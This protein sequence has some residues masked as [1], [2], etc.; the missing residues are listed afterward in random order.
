MY[1]NKIDD[2]FDNIINKFNIYL[3]KKSIIKKFVLDTNFVKYQNNIIN[4]IKDY[5][6]NINKKELSKIINL[7][8]LELIIDI[9]KRYIAFY[10]FFSISYY[11]KGDRELFITNLLEFSRDQKLSKYKIPN[12]FNSENN[13]KIIKYF[14]IIKNIIKL[15]EFKTM[16]R[17]KIILKNKPIYF[18]TTVEFFN[19][20]GEDYIKNYLIIKDNFH[21]IIKTIIFKNIYLNEEKNKMIDILKEKEIKNAEYRYIEIVVSKKDKIVDYNIIQQ[22]LNEKNIYN[23]AEEFYSYLENNKNIEEYNIIKQKEFID[24][25]FVKKILIPINDDC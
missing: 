10:M 19:N 17:I 22:Y 7:D 21:N 2:L 1:I 20:L 3:K 23:L 11:Y 9:I 16:E 4:V 6:D 15:T 8:N 12:F 14:S 13:S 25:L 18:Q 24:F 5:V